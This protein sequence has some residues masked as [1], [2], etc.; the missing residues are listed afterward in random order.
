MQ[1]IKHRINTKNGL[2]ETNRSFGIEMDVRSR[3]NQIVVTHDPFNAEA[4]LFEDWISEYRHGTLVVNVKEEGI[5]QRVCD[6]LNESGVIDY[7]LLD[8]SF[9]FMMKTLFSNE[10]RTAARLSEVE[11]IETVLKL[12]EVSGLFPDWV[13]IDCFSGDWTHLEKIASVKSLGIKTCL[14]S[15]E[16][17]GRNVDGE[18]DQILGLVDLNNL[19]AVCTKNPDLWLECMRD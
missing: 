7:F 3:G 17:Q 11:S 15:P 2:L 10:S 5:E 6:T 16:L 14:V 13:W 19:D 1:I 18:L 4:E 8:Q 9:P 12:K